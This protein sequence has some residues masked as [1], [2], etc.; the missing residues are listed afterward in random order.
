MRRAEGHEFGDFGI[1]VDLRL[2]HAAL[3]DLALQI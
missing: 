3:T 1:L 2:Q